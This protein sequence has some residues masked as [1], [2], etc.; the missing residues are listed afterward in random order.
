M[1]AVRAGRGAQTGTPG[2]VVAGASLGRPERA[3]PSS[4]PS[5]SAANVL[6]PVAASFQPTTAAAG[7]PFAPFLGPPRWPLSTARTC[8][9]RGP[10]SPHRLEMEAPPAAWRALPL[11]RGAQAQGAPWSAG[12]RGAPFALPGDAAQGPGKLRAH[13]PALG[14]APGI[15]AAH[16]RGRGSATF[17]RAPGAKAVLKSSRFSTLLLTFHQAE[18]SSRAGLQDQDVWPGTEVETEPRPP[19][20][21][22]SHLGSNLQRF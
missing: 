8:D 9:H 1:G 16:G 18:L 3:A 21:S 22:C 19:A 5:Y 14:V 7:G 4:L 12:V 15:N 11:H 2:S 10:L 6:F 13:P 17:V 20:A